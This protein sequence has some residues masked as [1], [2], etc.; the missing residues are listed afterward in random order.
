[1]PL[2]IVSS[3]GAFT[4]A[5]AKATGKPIL[6]LQAASTPARSTARTRCTNQP[7]TRQPRIASRV[8]AVDLAGV[9]AALQQQDGLAGGLGRG[10][11]EGAVGRNDDQRHLAALRRPAEA[12][13]LDD[14]GSARFQ[15]MEVVHGLGICRGRT[16]V[17][18]FRHRLPDLGDVFGGCGAGEE[19]DKA[20]DEEKSF[21]GRHFS[22]SH[23]HRKERKERKEH[24]KG[25]RMI[26]PSRLPLRILI[27]FTAAVAVAVPVP[28]AA[29]A[30]VSGIPGLLVRLRRPS[31]VPSAWSLGWW[32]EGSATTPMGRRRPATLPGQQ[33]ASRLPGEPGM[34]MCA[35]GCGAG[36]TLGHIVK[37]RTPRI[38][39]FPPTRGSLGS[40]PGCGRWLLPLS[41]LAVADRC[42]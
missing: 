13:H 6:L 2:V 4:P 41:L 9:D 40:G 37:P 30:P 3:D 29:P 11:R 26:G 27:L 33:T 32:I 10:R 12:G 8:L 31:V 34:T 22:P 19:Q 16:K 25:H 38:A 7:S 28:A 24:R 1:M 5:A 42:H 17:G 23:I 35:T 21:H 15:P 14:I 18:L 20:G 36:R 39:P